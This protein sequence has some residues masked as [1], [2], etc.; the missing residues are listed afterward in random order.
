MPPIIYKHLSE[1]NKRP[2]EIFNKMTHIRWVPVA[3]TY[4]P[5]CSGDW[6]QEDHGF[7]PAWAN[8]LWDP[9][10]KITRVKWTGGEAQATERR[11]CE[12]LFCKYEALSSNLS[13]SKN[14]IYKCK[15]T[16]KLMLVMPI[17]LAYQYTNNN[18][19]ERI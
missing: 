10:S 16:K 14:K 4:N 19:I 17:T 12:N 15:I 2:L 5:S 8:T 6:D 9:I 7:R 13:P 11:L 1:E 18:D 3:H